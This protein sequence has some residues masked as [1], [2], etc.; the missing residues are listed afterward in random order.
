MMYP[1]FLKADQKTFRTSI[2][3]LNKIRTELEIFVSEIDPLAA[4]KDQDFLQS[5]DFEGRYRKTEG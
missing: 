5:F 3:M 4:K 1:R 2:Y